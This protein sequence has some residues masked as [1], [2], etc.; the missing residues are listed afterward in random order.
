MQ[1]TTTTAET[2]RKTTRQPVPMN[3]V[4]TPALFATIG[5]VKAQP[6]LARFRFRATN[7]WLQGTHSR[8][9]MESFDGAGGEH[10]HV[11]EYAYDADHPQVLVGRDQGP[12][13]V[14]FLL[15]ALAACLTAGIGNVAAAR[16]VTLYQVESTVEGD[17]D[18][19]GILGI[20]GDVRN[21]YEGICVSFKV[22]GDAPPERLREL[23]AQSRARS[24]V[25]DVLTNGVPV[26]VSVDAQ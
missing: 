10:R 9:L 11:R 1:T 26:T 19:R 12:T 8:T 24:A 21:G 23:V 20:S 16:G 15:H 17:I 4:D 5:A 6:E 14:E 22:K 25:F 3:G 7:V 2:T 18:L 13:P